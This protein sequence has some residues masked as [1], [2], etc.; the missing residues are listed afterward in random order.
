MILAF[1]L[2]P[3]IAVA[4]IG[5]HFAFGGTDS[6]L[7]HA[8]MA[9]TVVTTLCVTLMGRFPVSWV[10]V[11]TAFSAVPVAAPLVLCHVCAQLM[12]HHASRLDESDAWHVLC[13]MMARRWIRAGMIAS[14]MGVV[15]AYYWWDTWDRGRVPDIQCMVLTD[16]LRLMSDS[17]APALKGAFLAIA[18]WYGV[19]FVRTVRIMRRLQSGRAAAEVPA[20]ES[21]Y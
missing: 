6:T 15:L 12:V 4:W 9:A 2:Q 16:P 19:Q 3:L 1:A 14:A 18:L 5:A 11:A 8:A 7:Y 21:S 17:F 13:A 20:G 10:I